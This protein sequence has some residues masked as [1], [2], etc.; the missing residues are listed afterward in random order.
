MNHRLL[1]MLKKVPEDI[2]SLTVDELIARLKKESD[3]QKKERKEADKAI[4]DKFSGKCI[5]FSKPSGLFG[6]ETIYVQIDSIKPKTYTTGWERVFSI[7]GQRIIFSHA[8]TGVRELNPSDVRDSMEESSLNKA[9]IIT[10]EEFDAA[11]N[12]CNLVKSMLDKMIK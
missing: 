8:F 1:E 7:G 11:N 3:A 10:Q 4:C 12:H 5:K 6:A 2:K 9:S